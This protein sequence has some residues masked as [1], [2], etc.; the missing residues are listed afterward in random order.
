M[1]TRRIIALILI[2]FSQYIFP[3]AI[4]LVDPDE[5]EKDIKVLKSTS[6]SIEWC[7]LLTIPIEEALYHLDEYKKRIHIVHTI[8]NRYRNR[9]V[10][11]ISVFNGVVWLKT[12][13]DK[14]LEIFGEIHRYMVR[15]AGVT[16]KK[17]RLCIY[18]KKHLAMLTG[19]YSDCTHQ[20][21]IEGFMEELLTDRDLLYE[22]YYYSCIS[23]HL[24]NRF[25]LEER[26]LIDL[27]NECCQRIVNV[28]ALRLDTIRGLEWLYPGKN[29][30]E[31]WASLFIDKELFA[32][33]YMLYSEASTYIW[34]YFPINFHKILLFHNEL[35]ANAEIY[36]NVICR[37]YIFSML[38]SESTDSLNADAYS[39]YIYKAISSWSE[40]LSSKIDVLEEKYLKPHNQVPWGKECW[41]SFVHSCFVREKMPQ[42]IKDIWAHLDRSLERLN[43]VI[44]TS[45]YNVESMFTEHRKIY[46]QSMVTELENVCKNDEFGFYTPLTV[47]HVLRK[48]HK[49]S[50]DCAPSILQIIK[51]VGHRT[52]ADTY[53]DS[54]HLPLIMN[55]QKKASEENIFPYDSQSMDGKYIPLIKTDTNCAEDTDFLGIVLTYHNILVGNLF[56][57]LCAILYEK[58]AGCFGIH[59]IYVID[60][61]IETEMKPHY[62]ISLAYIY[63]NVVD[64]TMGIERISMCL[65]QEVQNIIK[66]CQPKKVFMPDYAEI[67]L[68]NISEYI[69]LSSLTTEERVALGHPLP[70]YSSDSMEDLI[71]QLKNRHTTAVAYI[72]TYKLLLNMQ[73]DIY[74]LLVPKYI[75]GID[76]LYIIDSACL[77]K[78]HYSNTIDLYRYT[79]VYTAYP[80]INMLKQYLE[81][82]QMQKECPNVLQMSI[83]EYKNFKTAQK[84]SS[85]TQF[86]KDCAIL[87]MFYAGMHMERV[88]R[89]YIVTLVI[90]FSNSFIRFFTPK[91]LSDSV[92]NFLSSFI[93][94]S[95]LDHKTSMP[96]GLS[97]LRIN[98]LLDRTL[99]E[100]R[101]II[102]LQPG[103][104]TS[105][106]ISIA[107]SEVKSFHYLVTRLNNSDS[108]LA[109]SENNQM[110]IDQIEKIYNRV[111]FTEC[112]ISPA[113]LQ[114]EE[115]MKINAEKVKNQCNMHINDEALVS[116]APIRTP[117]KVSASYEKK[118]IWHSNKKKAQR[119][120]TLNSSN[121]WVLLASTVCILSVFGITIFGIYLW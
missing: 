107:I 50:I 18:L 35:F 72:R 62:L 86:T 114:D 65:M 67:N 28:K 4:P 53:T 71:C 47:E 19:T 97:E 113:P 33:F 92:V 118:N 109:V 91:R 20:D 59:S 39:S 119:K 93:I 11:G 2:A 117:K 76:K 34:E 42:L 96:V 81:E 7:S 106:S 30:E 44:D 24:L 57:A 21:W 83:E 1:E 69:D 112:P 90:W 95:P 36:N 46:T 82:M 73:R 88:F 111:K 61:I 38:K 9:L 70:K 108:G 78:C 63:K 68:F 23:I 89:S 66:V 12:T 54:K 102:F 84:T 52:F 101:D 60:S 87:E 104:C 100:E 116:S 99:Y 120:N 10:H 6:V 41:D 80:Q 5:I 49:N 64:R 43:K 115:H 26:E 8:L 37:S 29:R 14:Y 13:T 98:I 121:G 55:E 31:Q 103:K 51:L 48:L 79:H 110:V 16:K 32:L 25:S 45:Q 58:W 3:T 105:V 17:E 40:P 27:Y 56:T 94:G 22:N 15:D 77:P 85:Y 75:L 74:T